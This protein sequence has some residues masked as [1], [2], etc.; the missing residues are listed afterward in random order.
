M[1]F[2]ITIKTKQNCRALPKDVTL[3]HLVA[4][5]MIPCSHC[6]TATLLSPSI[7]GQLCFSVDL[8]LWGTYSNWKTAVL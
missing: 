2:T 3:D 4:M 8:L 7:Q 1:D 6:I 5:Y